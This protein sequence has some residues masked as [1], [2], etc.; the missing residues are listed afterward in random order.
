MSQNS[1][2][3]GS[4]RFAP[5]GQD[6]Q[7][8]QK[9]A[10]SSAGRRRFAEPAIGQRSSAAMRQRGKR[11]KCDGKRRRGGTSGSHKESPQGSNDRRDTDHGGRT[12]DLQG[13]GR[14]MEAEAVAGE[15]KCGG[16]FEGDGC[17]GCL[18][19][20]RRISIDETRDPRSRFP[21]GGLIYR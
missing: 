1:S 5:V 20:L 21:P 4:R 19:C 15:K 17:L 10:S 7:R 9:E 6:H 8:S 3:A 18:G 16:G 2:S 13:A 12:T 14:E 11:A